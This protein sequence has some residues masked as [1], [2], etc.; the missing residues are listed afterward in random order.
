MYYKNFYIPNILLFYKYILYMGSYFSSS[1][2]V[3]INQNFNLSITT[4]TEYFLHDTSGN[5]YTNYSLV[6]DSNTYYQSDTS[7]NL[8]D[9]STITFN[10]ILISSTGSYT[11]ILNGI[12]DISTVEILEGSISVSPTCYLKGTK[13]LC[14]I[15]SNIELEA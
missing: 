6:I 7:G 5:I 4:F 11:F 1:P 10:D 14:K 9:T 8:N 2:T 15:N 3:I 12:S 13:I